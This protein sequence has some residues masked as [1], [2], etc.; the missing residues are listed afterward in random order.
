MTYSK[1]ELMTMIKGMHDASSTLYYSAVKIGNHPFIEF[2]GLMNEYIQICEQTLASGKDFTDAS[3]HG[4]DA[5]VVYPYNLEYLAEKFT[6][7][8]ETTLRVPENKRIWDAA[9]AKKVVGAVGFEPTD[10]L[11]VNETV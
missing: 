3:I 7:I 9:V 10:L 2:C 8:F 11:G 5:L 6:C 4:E 1:E